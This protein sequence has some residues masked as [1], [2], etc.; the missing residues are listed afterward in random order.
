MNGI[1]DSH[2]KIIYRTKNTT[3]RINERHQTRKKNHV[4]TANC[5]SEMHRC[6]IAHCINAHT[7]QNAMTKYRQSRTEWQWTQAHTNMHDYART[8]ATTR[9]EWVGATQQRSY[10]YRPLSMQSNKQTI[11]PHTRER[12]RETASEMRK[13][14]SETFNNHIHKNV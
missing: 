8:A 11:S 2:I 14:S 6:K 1:D 7:V 3:K 4:R 9:A 5:H 12:A 10:P 13:C